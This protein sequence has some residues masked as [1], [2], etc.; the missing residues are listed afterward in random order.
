MLGHKIDPFN[1][2]LFLDLY[3]VAIVDGI[4][5]SD[6]LKM[7]YRIGEQRSVSIEEIQEIIRNPSKSSTK[8][9]KDEDKL[10]YLMDIS[11]IIIS[12]AAIKDEELYLWDRIAVKIL[13]EGS[14]I[15]YLKKSIF[16][17]VIE[18][19]IKQEE[20]RLENLKQ[21]LLDELDDKIL[22]EHIQKTA[23]STKDKIDEK[24]KKV[25]CSFPQKDPPRIFMIGEFKQSKQQLR[26]LFRPVFS[27]LGINLNNRSY[28]FAIGKDYQ[29]VKSGHKMLITN[30]TN[31]V[32]DLLIYGPHPHNIHGHGAKSW[33]GILENTNTVVFGN[34]NSPPS[35]NKIEEYARNF[36]IEW[37]SSVVN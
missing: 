23:E 13:G 26:S 7:L 28:K 9:L 33:E 22:N 15:E 34:H 16:K 31:G 37:T 2:L 19:Y 17:R 27:E 20:D 4:L 25:D 24:V 35:K 30:A 11:K 3:R 18:E 29:D 12:D 14:S 1:Q 8:L 36:S 10:Q 5:D 6:E 32:Y 21:H